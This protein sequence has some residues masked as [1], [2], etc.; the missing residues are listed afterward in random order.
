[1]FRNQ[2]VIDPGQRLLPGLFD[3]TGRTFG[4]VGKDVCWRKHRKSGEGGWSRGGTMS[5]KAA[6]VA[7]INDS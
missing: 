1:M 5:L 6:D 2:D 7:V 3:G 4:T